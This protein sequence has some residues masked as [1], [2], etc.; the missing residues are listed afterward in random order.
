MDSDVAQALK[1]IT[2]Y[3]TQHPDQALVTIAADCELGAGMRATVRC[4]RHTIEVDEPKQFGG[5]GTAATP[6]QY[7]LAALG[8][9]IALTYRVWATSLDLIVD[10][11]QVEV[12]GDLDIRGLLGEAEVRPGFQDVRVDVRIEGPERHDRYEHLTSAVLRHCPILDVFANPVAVTTTC[13][14]D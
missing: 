9:C 3:T 8:S 12:R 4:G 1:G 7:A 10:S 13:H 2:A 5:T 14:A 11:L 6:A